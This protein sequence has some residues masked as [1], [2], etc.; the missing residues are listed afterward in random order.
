MGC[1]KNEPFMAGNS[2]LETVSFFNLKLRMLAAKLRT[3][4][5]PSN[6]E[7]LHKKLTSVQKDCFLKL[8]PAMV[9]HNLKLRFYLSFMHFGCRID[10]VF[11]F[12]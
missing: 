4:L 1:H 10:C 2:P 5:L 7:Q 3:L 11:G 12:L 9:K 6:W 8:L